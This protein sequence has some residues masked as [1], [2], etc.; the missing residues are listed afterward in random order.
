MKTAHERA[1][2]IVD[3]VTHIINDEYAEAMLLSAIELSL[4][5]FV[6]DMRIEAF[7]KENPVVKSLNASVSTV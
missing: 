7:E 5:N 3:A 1:R 4:I 2:E 6:R